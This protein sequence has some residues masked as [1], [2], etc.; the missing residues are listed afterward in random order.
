MSAVGY[1][2]A[3][4]SGFFFYSYSQQG[5]IKEGPFTTRHDAEMAQR[6]WGNMAGKVFQEEKP[7]RF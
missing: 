5:K 4:Y 3:R 7:V 6:G 1:G 2:W